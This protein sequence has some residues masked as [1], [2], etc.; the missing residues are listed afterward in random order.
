[1]PVEKWHVANGSFVKIDLGP[2]WVLAD[3]FWGIGPARGGER[4]ARRLGSRHAREIQEGG[5][6]A[7]HTGWK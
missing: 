5:Q 3:C 1:M 2:N 4:E 6:V 7:L